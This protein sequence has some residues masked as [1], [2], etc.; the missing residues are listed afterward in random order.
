[1][2]TRLI[3]RIR[4]NNNVTKKNI[5]DLCLKWISY[6]GYPQGLINADVI[7]SINSSH[8][9]YIVS[10]G[11]VHIRNFENP[12]RRQDFFGFRFK[13]IKKGI[14]WCSDAVYSN[15]DGIKSILVQVT[16]TSIK[17]E[18]LPLPKVPFLVELLIKNGYCALD[19]DIPVDGI[20]L[21]VTK[22]N[23]ELCAKVIRG[24]SDNILP[25]VYVSRDSWGTAL[26]CEE[27]AYDLKGVAHVLFEGEQN[28]S[29]IMMKLTHKRNVFGNYVGIYFPGTKYVK[30]F[31]IFQYSHD[32]VK[33]M[34]DLKQYLFTRFSGG[35]IVNYYTWSHLAFLQNAS[36]SSSSQK[37]LREFLLDYDDTIQESD[38]TISELHNKISNLEEKIKVLENAVKIKNE[39]TPESFSFNRGKEREFYTG[40]MRDLLI[41]LLQQGKIR[42]SNNSRAEHLIDSMLSCNKLTGENEKLMKGLE[43]ILADGHKLTE[44]DLK[45][46]EKLGFTFEHRNHYRFTFHD[47][48]R[49]KFTTAT[50]PSD[51]RGGKNNLSDFRKKLNL[52]IKL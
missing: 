51:H 26:N 30:K 42:C 49:Y 48:E 3:T 38:K 29:R 17:Y 22:E 41:Y 47:D 32:N 36:L 21:K 24:E 25:V 18:N 40:E 9:E 13:L 20:P 27:L 44:Q 8:Y 46:L 4:L 33:M 52:D 34:N 23:V 16:P 1:M 19:G 15:I 5:Q 2:S 50:T 45:D 28:V 6:K 7:N 10:G 31:D 37:E 14:T 11:E 35:I 39:T 43:K 12:K